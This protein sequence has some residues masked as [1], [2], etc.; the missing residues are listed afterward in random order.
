MNNSTPP[1][2]H[3]YI[4]YSNVG[5]G[6]LAKSVELYYVY[7]TGYKKLILRKE[8]KQREC[9][10]AFLAAFTVFSQEIDVCHRV[11]ENGEWLIE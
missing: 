10:G 6:W 1:Q 3:A 5:T 11:G 2:V 9:V 4:K 7:N 8:I